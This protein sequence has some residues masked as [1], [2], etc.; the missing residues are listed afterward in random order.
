MHACVYACKHERTRSHLTCLSFSD[1]HIYTAAKLRRLKG[2]PLAEQR[3]LHGFRSPKSASID[4]NELF[5]SEQRAHQLGSKKGKNGG[6]GGGKTGGKGSSADELPYCNSCL[7]SV[8]WDGPTH[9]QV[10]NGV[11]ELT[12]QITSAPD[13]IAICDNCKCTALNTQVVIANVEGEC[14]LY[15]GIDVLE[16]TMSTADETG[17]ADIICPDT[18]YRATAS[19]ESYA[20]PDGGPRTRNIPSTTGLMIET[21]GPVVTIDLASN[22]YIYCI[23]VCANPYPPPEKPSKSAKGSSVPPLADYLPF[24]DKFPAEIS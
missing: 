13:D 9:F 24:E 14:D 15:Q 23:V 17:D 11:L 1:V 7:F 3:K 22:L 12:D 6:G 19:C 2:L 5:F 10:I 16:F 4:Q 8:K 18:T 21:E 20:N